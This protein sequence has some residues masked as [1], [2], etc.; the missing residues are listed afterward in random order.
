MAERKIAA[1][2]YLLS[3]DPAGATAYDNIVCL[4]N[5]SFN[6]TTETNDA[7]TFCGPDSSAGNVTVTIP[8]TAVTLLDPLTGK[9]SAPD[10]FDL[11]N[12]GASFSWEIGPATPTTGDMVKTGMGYFSS[13]TETYDEGAFGQF[14]GTITVSGAV[15]QTLTP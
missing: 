5:Y 1:N 10:I 7:N 4:L 15:T 6:G 14:S 9:I 13:Y 11:W 12:T 8:F 2:S 3:I